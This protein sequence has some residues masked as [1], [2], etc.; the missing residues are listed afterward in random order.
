M[1]LQQKYDDKSKEYDKTRAS[2]M[3]LVKE[4]VCNVIHVI[5]RIRVCKARALDRQHQAEEQQDDASN[6]LDQLVALHVTMTFEQASEVDINALETETAEHEHHLS[7]MKKDVDLSA[8]S[9]FLEK[10]ADWKA[11][12]K[13][14]DE[15]TSRR[16]AS[17]YTLDTL[18]NKRHTEFMEGFTL[19]TTKLKEMYQ[20]ITLGGD[21]ELELVDTLDPFTE[22]VVFSVRPPKKSW[23]N[24][25]NLSGGEKTL[26][27]LALVFALHQYKPTPIYVMDEV[28]DDVC[29]RHHHLD[30]CS[31]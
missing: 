12:M 10:E 25:S 18:K 28:C 9:R 5:C 19:I 13:E 23:K 29:C 6:D 8:I 22:G 4:Y 17:R 27:S 30:R 24:I 16:D 7:S 15:V 26:S 20:M 21:A 14:L 3:N 2:I 1:E 11:R 31:T